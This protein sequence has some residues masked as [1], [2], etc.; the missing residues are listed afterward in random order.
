MGRTVHD[1]IQRVRLERAR[2]LVSTTNLPLSQVALQAG[3]RHL[4]YMTSMFRRHVG[5]TPA[6]YRERARQ[7][8]QMLG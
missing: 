5:F 6:K 7:M 4:T 8:S 2:Q 1:E 3:F